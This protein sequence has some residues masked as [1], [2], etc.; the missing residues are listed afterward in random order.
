MPCGGS[1]VFFLLCF[2]SLSFWPFIKRKR[3][4]LYRYRARDGD[5]FENSNGLP[6][7][8]SLACSFL[9]I[10]DQREGCISRDDPYKKEGRVGRGREKK[11][12]VKFDSQSG[13]L[14]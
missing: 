1:L 6:W 12:N 13:S 10:P 7:I 8:V 3:V 4:S 11:K 5:M 14:L 9:K 2:P